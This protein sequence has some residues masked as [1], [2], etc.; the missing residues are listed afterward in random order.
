MQVEQSV[1]EY[2]RTAAA[3]IAAGSFEAREDA[4]EA[5]I[6]A[7]ESG[8]HFHLSSTNKIEATIRLNHEGG[9]AKNMADTVCEMTFTIL[10]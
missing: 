4:H 10:L 6:K 9:L 8:V 1:R 5:I 2:V 7:R 3:M